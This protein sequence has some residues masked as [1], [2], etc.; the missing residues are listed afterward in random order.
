MGWAEPPVTR[1]CSA[2][3]RER[4][5]GIRLVGGGGVVGG[6][7]FGEG[8][9]GG[10]GGGSGRGRG[11][12]GWLRRGAGRGRRGGGRLGRGAGRGRRGGWLGVTA[13]CCCLG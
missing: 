6:V 2:C 5:R 1:C 8:N 4:R 9:R 7:R 3:V 12:G 10:I 13:I 11:G